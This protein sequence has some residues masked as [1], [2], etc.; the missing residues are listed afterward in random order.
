MTNVLK[1]ADVNS[2]V[3]GKATGTGMDYNDNFLFSLEKNPSF[4]PKVLIAV[5]V[6]FFVFF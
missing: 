4:I 6:L 2:N 1:F 3:R 5:V